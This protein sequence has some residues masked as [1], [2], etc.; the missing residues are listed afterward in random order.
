MTLSLGLNPPP[1]GVFALAD[2]PPLRKMWPGFACGGGFLASEFLPGEPVVNGVSWLSI[3]L[4]LVGYVYYLSCV[5]RLHAVA[6]H[7]S[8][9]LE[10]VPYP[11]EPGSAVAR[12]FIPFYNLYWLVRW[13]FLLGTFLNRHLREGKMASGLLVG[14]LILGTLLLRAFDTG[15]AMILLFWILSYV[16]DKV[17]LLTEQTQ[18]TL[19]AP[20]VFD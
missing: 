18:A 16:S 10:Q 9:V 4:A 14:F 8:P 20:S 2:L 5:S 12:H 11:I 1:L 13:P 15:I 17:R 19:G 3:A 6:S 7:L